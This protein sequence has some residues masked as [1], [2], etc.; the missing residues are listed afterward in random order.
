MLERAT[1]LIVLANREPY[2]HERD[3]RGR[4]VTSRCSSGVVNAVE[5]LLLANSGVWIAEGMG[6]DDRCA[7]VERDGLDV[8][9]ES[10]RYRLRRVWLTT[11]ERRGYYYGFA[12]SALWPLCHRTAIEPVFYAGDFRTYELVNRRFADAV[13][14]EAS[15]RS[16]VVLVQD[17]HFALAPALIRRQLPLSRISTFWHIPWPR[18]E[19]FSIC[20]WSRELLEGLLG[21]TSVGLQT[22][23]DRMNFFAAVEQLPGAEVNRPSCTVRYQGREIAVGVFPASIVWTSDDAEQPSASVCCEQV[24][25]ELGLD[26]ATRIG[27]GVDRLDYTKGI[28]HKFLAVERLLER[29]PSLSGRF[30]FVQLAQPSRECIRAYQQTRE[31]VFETAARINARFRASNWHPIRVLEAHHPAST[32]ARFLR[33]ADMCY[34][35]SLHDG[36]N[37]VG[38]E[39]IRERHDERGV[40]VLST[41][42]GAAQELTDALLVNP[43]DVDA[44]A[45]AFERALQMPLPEQRDR[46]RR[47][48]G[49]V[50]RNDASLWARSILES[51]ASVEALAERVLA[52]IVA[53]L[54]PLAPLD[55]VSYPPLSASDA[56]AS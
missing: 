55:P 30:V 23:N 32:V 41:F 10:P 7:A 14:E 54:A 39:F 11:D 9:V 33:A 5:P 37:L 45:A 21:S 38:K 34:V 24:R 49:I 3:R 28:E 13:A 46:L 18:P 29:K 53:A 26:E 44:A 51:V 43:Y 27:V 36:M 25:R 17:Y 31:R 8:P 2:R 4:V 42:A 35:G 20:P 48:R 16:P 56:S 47:L 15:S 19:T 6:D 40:L 12:N 52:P 1:D 50:S 22:A